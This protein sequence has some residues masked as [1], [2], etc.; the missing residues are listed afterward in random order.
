MCVY[1][2]VCMCVCMCVC[3]CVCVCVCL[4]PFIVK[5]SSVQI[6]WNLKEQLNGVMLKTFLSYAKSLHRYFGMNHQKISN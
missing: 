4:R 2:C 6:S 3:V 5:V 1:V